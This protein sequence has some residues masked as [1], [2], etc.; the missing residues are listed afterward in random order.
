MQYIQEG[1]TKKKLLF[2]MILS[3]FLPK[4]FQKVHKSRQIF[5]IATK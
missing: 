5:K 1:F 4:D 2:Y 3:K